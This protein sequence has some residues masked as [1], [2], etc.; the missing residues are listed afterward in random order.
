VDKKDIW[1]GVDLRDFFAAA[2]L[3]G[4]MSGMFSDPQSYELFRQGAEKREMSPKDLAAKLVYAYADA[5]LAE[6]N[7]PA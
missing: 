3:T 1:Q 6:R 2:A 5:L 4:L 7:K